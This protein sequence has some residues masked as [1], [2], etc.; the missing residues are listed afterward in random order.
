MGL[1]ENDEARRFYEKVGGQEFR[2]GSHYWGGKEYDMI[3]YLYD[4]AHILGGDD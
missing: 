3:S 4:L 2:T 1:K